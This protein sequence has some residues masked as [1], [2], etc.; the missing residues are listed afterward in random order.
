MNSVTKLAAS[1][2]GAALALGAMGAVAQDLPQLR[3]SRTG[4]VWTP[5]IVEEASA[6]TS[7]SSSMPVPW[8]FALMVAPAAE[9]METVPWNQPGKY[10]WSTSLFQGL[11]PR[12]CHPGPLYFKP[13]L[14]LSVTANWVRVTA[15]SIRS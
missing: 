4:K 5:E 3:D 6:P 7:P 14:P 12:R 11:R 1:T 10:P 8:N 15:S 13:E 2:L 9:L